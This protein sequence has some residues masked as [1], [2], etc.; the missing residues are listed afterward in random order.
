MKRKLSMPL[1]LGL[2]LVLAGVGV[3]TFFGVRMYRGN[4]TSQRL[5]AE[6]EALLPERNLGVP[7]IYTNTAMPVLELRGADYVAL[8]E[9]PDHG[10]KLPVSNGWDQNK[11]YATPCRFSG[12]AYD[13]TLIIGGGNDL[14]QFS[15]C[16]KIENGTTVL[17][18]DMIGAQFSYTV[19]RVDRSKHA[20]TQWLSEENA[21][22][23][24]F[25]QD[26]YSMEYIA[27]RCI[28]TATPNS[29]KIPDGN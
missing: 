29:I 15:F 10:V 8:L 16:N 11:L 1:I 2:I 19:Y 25:C 22:L 12:S 17:I 21:D 5:A 13:G 23:T 6:L 7:G 24:L 28:S 14:Q 26:V 4:Q 27:V 3:G 9:I 20:Q 18:T